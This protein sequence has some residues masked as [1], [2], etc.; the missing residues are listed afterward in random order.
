MDNIKISKIMNSTQKRT[1]YVNGIQYQ[2]NNHLVE[3]DMIKENIPET[4]IEHSPLASVISSLEK[5]EKV[6][7]AKQ[8]MEDIAIKQYEERM[9]EISKEK[10]QREQSIKDML[11]QNQECELE[12]PSVSYQ[13]NE[14]DNKADLLAFVETLGIENNFD[15]RMSL[16]GLKTKVLE[17]IN[18]L[19]QE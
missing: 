19:P 9:I 3:T 18:N 17:A 5:Q 16:A 2:V 8:A 4:T 10:E 14:F 6:T 1:K 15:K 11:S 13:I 7:I 12:N